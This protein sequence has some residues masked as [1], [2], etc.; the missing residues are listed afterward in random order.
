MN[1]KAE[2]LI[3]DHVFK[4][5]VNDGFQQSHAEQA[6]AAALRSYR[7]NTN[8]KNAIKQAIAQCKKA[9]KRVEK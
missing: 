1:D 9:H 4:E 6:G 5:L 3:Y 8:H 2:Q 7:R